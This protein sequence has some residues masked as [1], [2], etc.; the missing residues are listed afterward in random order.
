MDRLDILGRLGLT[1][2]EDFVGIDDRARFSD[3]PVRGSGFAHQI[4]VSLALSKNSVSTVTLVRRLWPA[5]RSTLPS[6][7]EGS[8]SGYVSSARLLIGHRE[9]SPIRTMRN[10][11]I[12]DRPDTHGAKIKATIDTDLDE[13]KRLVKVGDQ[14]SLKSALAL[15]RGTLLP[16]DDEEKLPWLKTERAGLRVRLAKAVA[17]H[18]GWG[19][20]RSAQVVGAFLEE[21][22][23]TLLEVVE[24]E[25]AEG[26]SESSL[27]HA[28]NHV[29]PLGPEPAPQ[30]PKGGPHHRGSR[31]RREEERRERL[32]KEAEERANL[33]RRRL[34]L[35][36]STTLSLIAAALLIGLV[37]QPWASHAPPH[38]QLE[39]V[40]DQGQSSV[41]LSP[42]VAKVMSPG[43][44]CKDPRTGRWP[45]FGMG[46]PAE[47]F[48]LD[49]QMNQD[50]A[51]DGRTWQITAMV[52]PLD[53][54]DW[55]SG[56]PHS[57]EMSAKIVRNGQTV[58]SH[59]GRFAYFDVV[60]D[61]PIRVSQSPRYPYAALIPAAG[62]E[63]HF[64]SR[65]SPSQNLRGRLT[66]DTSVPARAF[67]RN[68]G[69]K[70]R[71]PL[72]NLRGPVIDVIGS[73]TK[74][75]VRADRQT[76]LHGGAAPFLNLPFRKGDLLTVTVRTPFA[77]R[78][79]PRPVEK[80]RVG[81][82]R[83]PDKGSRQR[84][85]Q[86]A[87]TPA[88][89]KANASWR[90]VS[91]HRT[92][93]YKISLKDLVVPRESKWRAFFNRSESGKPIH[94][95]LQPND[96]DLSDGDPRSV[97]YLP[98]VLS[99]PQV[100][101]FGPI[102]GFE[103]DASRGSISSPSGTTDLLLGQ[104]LS[105]LSDEGI[106]A[107]T[108]RQSS[109]ISTGTPTDQAVLSGKATVTIDDKQLEN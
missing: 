43:C 24:R 103:S 75:R 9:S 20:S 107:G 35:R 11:Y 97:Y 90:L 41:R 70:P 37:W 51:F 83:T 98:P 84:K 86:L 32:R 1:I 49:G 67:D 57:L 34:I 46:I 96:D 81:P 102:V 93:A 39:L 99:T 27:S 66:V 44:G 63:T 7:P 13:F 88:W 65:Q 69:N 74:L 42:D 28:E 26:A 94:A 19:E 104:H 50:R 82:L 17:Q 73:T 48:T 71:D 108:Y 60:T 95:A 22:D 8:L 80:S 38:V 62:G 77:L 61:S 105:V 47:R 45:W 100:G 68:G 6:K 4:L 12:L 91:P 14:G 106:E 78:L 15:V 79:I 87:E 30:T 29:Q 3:E 55:Y 64:R 101:V 23:G 109:L 72:S 36:G 31:T 92:P 16:D 56:S 40:S 33:R 2:G 53:Y 85:P 52:P 54:V 76:Q 10:G 25:L 18:T 21:P 89:I 58:W 59:R 5:E